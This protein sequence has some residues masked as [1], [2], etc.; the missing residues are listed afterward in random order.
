M[1]ELTFTNLQPVEGLFNTILA[2]YPVITSSD[3]H[4]PWA[5]GDYS[6][7]SAHIFGGAGAG[8]IIVQ[9]SN[10]PRVVSDPGSAVWVT[11]KDTA[12]ADMSYAAATGGRG[13][14][15]DNFYFNRVS[16]SGAV[17]AGQAAFCGRRSH[18]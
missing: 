15:R 12:D 9:G 5:A 8:N 16:T 6:D 3:T 10:D 18:S 2:H 1:A 13:T 17:T 4:K 7:K 11:C 14:I